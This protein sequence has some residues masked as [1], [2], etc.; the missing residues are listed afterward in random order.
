M[1]GDRAFKDAIYEQISRMGKAFANPHRLELVDLLCQGPMTVEQLARKSNMSIGSASQHLQHLRASRV[2]RVVPR[3]TTR[4]YHLTD[5]KI[6]ELFRT[7]RSMSERYYAEMSTITHA[8]FDA[9]EPVEELDTEALQRRLAE[10]MVILVDVRPPE[11]YLAGH[12][13]GALSFPVDDLED[14]LAELPSDKPIVAYCRG[15]YCVLALQAADILRQNGYRVSRL[16]DGVS[17]WQA[18]GLPIE[19]GHRVS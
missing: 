3:G 15:P 14:H 10:N 9:R 19:V 13:P 5:A 12:W 6:G 2:V 16:I 17:D 18:V 7:L 1:V 11:E 8:F 4:E